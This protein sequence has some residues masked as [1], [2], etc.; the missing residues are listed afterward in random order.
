MKKSIGD[1][2]IPTGWSFE[3]G[4]E[5]VKKAGANLGQPVTTSLRAASL[6]IRRQR[7]R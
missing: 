1:N 5:L 4:L 2:M 6:T 3:Q 7:T